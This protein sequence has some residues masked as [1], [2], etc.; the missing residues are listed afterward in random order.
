MTYEGKSGRQ[1]VAVVD[2]GGVA[3]QTPASDEVTAFALK[4][5]AA[6]SSPRA[7]GDK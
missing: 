7:A 6:G 3:G 5:N 4:Q 2:T 1:Y